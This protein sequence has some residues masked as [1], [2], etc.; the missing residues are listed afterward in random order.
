MECGFGPLAASPS[1]RPGRQTPSR[2]H[3][4]GAPQALPSS[5]PRGAVDS[6]QD[7]WRGQSP[8]GRGPAFPAGEGG[9]AEASGCAQRG[10]IHPEMRHRVSPRSRPVSPG[11]VSSPGAVIRGGSAARRGIEFLPAARTLA[12]ADLLRGDPGRGPPCA[13]SEGVSVP[14]GRWRL[15]RPASRPARQEAGELLHMP[16]PGD[17]ESP[18]PGGQR[19]AGSVPPR[20]RRLGSEPGS[21][22]LYLKGSRDE[23]GGPWRALWQPREMRGKEKKHLVLRNNLPPWPVSSVVR[24]PASELSG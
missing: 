2:A 7:A 1:S 13:A 15:E 9:R 23:S 11:P 6:G 4:A 3:A 8:V 17:R 12:V 14:G 10:S 20:P 16:P 22:C 18:E 24:A 21:P 19:D 5:P